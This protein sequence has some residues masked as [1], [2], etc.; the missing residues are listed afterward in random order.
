MVM[1]I[2]VDRKWGR[3]VMVWVTFLNF[4]FRT[5]F[6]INARMMGIGKL[7]KRLNKLRSTVFLIILPKVGALK[8]RQ[9]HSSPTHSLPE[10][11]LLAL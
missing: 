5:S 1:M 3:Y 10:N 9:N 8:K 7:H 4:M 2:T 11:P 6:S